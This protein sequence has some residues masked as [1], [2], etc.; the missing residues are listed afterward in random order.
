MKKIALTSVAILAVVASIWLWVA[1]RFGASWETLDRCLPAAVEAAGWTII[2]L[3]T[4]DSSDFPI[5]AVSR[6][7]QILHPQRV[8]PRLGFPNSTRPYILEREQ[9]HTRV[10]CLVRFSEGMV[11]Q[12]GV[13][14]PTSAR[15]EAISLR[16]VLRRIFPGEGVSADEITGVQPFTGANAG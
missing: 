9:S 15:Q 12:I 6:T 4:V 3:R 5:S 13:R 16:D 8:Q 7:R 10:Q 1:T 14:Y 11:L 2:E